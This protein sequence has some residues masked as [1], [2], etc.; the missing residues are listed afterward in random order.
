MR[1]LIRT[2]LELFR[3]RVLAGGKLPPRPLDAV[4]RDAT[5]LGERLIV[6]MRAKLVIGELHAMA[7]PPPP[8]PTPSP[9]PTRRPTAAPRRH[10]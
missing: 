9:R 5:R 8:A 6:A 3:A 10:R 4:A 7:Q 1:A 2:E